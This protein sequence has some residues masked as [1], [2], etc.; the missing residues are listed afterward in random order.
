MKSFG[1]ALIASFCIQTA[2][3]VWYVQYPAAAVLLCIAAA[4]VVVQSVKIAGGGVRRR[5]MRRLRDALASLILLGALLRFIVMQ[6]PFGGGDRYRPPNPPTAMNSTAHEGS[7]T[8]VDNSGDHTGVILLPERQQHTTLVPPLPA[9]PSTLFDAKH[10]NPLSIP[11]YG[12]YWFFK[13]P[14]TKPP[15]DSYQTH[16]TPAEMTFHAPDGRP[17]IMEAHQN[18]GKLIDLACCREIRIEIQNADRYPGT[19]AVELVLVNNRE[20]QQGQVSLGNAPVT[21]APGWLTGDSDSPMR[22]TLTFPIPAHPS[23]RQFD[24][25]MIRFPRKK[26][27]IE[28]SARIAIDRF[29]LVPRG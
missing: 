2:A 15:L 8:S 18:L 13:P 17:L 29:I 28:R 10:Q 14:D 21:S 23:I 3:L 27:R 20:G 5:T 24:E 1:S 6:L 16:G 12:A 9:M 22:E 7:S 25:L 11:F 26:T 19:V 4:V